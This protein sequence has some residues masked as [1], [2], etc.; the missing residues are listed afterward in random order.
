MYKH[1]RCLDYQ[2]RLLGST[3]SIFLNN[4]MNFNIV[5]PRIHNSAIIKVFIFRDTA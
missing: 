4:V 3:A 2:Y 5:I 1:R